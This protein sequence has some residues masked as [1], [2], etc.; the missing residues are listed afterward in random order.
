MSCSEPS[1]TVPP[2]PDCPAG[3]PGVGLTPQRLDVEVPHIER[4]VF[5]ELAAR[6]DGVA[7]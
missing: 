6:F 4:V 5:D 7:H 2:Q 3:D 1:L